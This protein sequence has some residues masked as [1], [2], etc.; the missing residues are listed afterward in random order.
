MLSDAFW[1]SRFDA[2]PH[3][4]GTAVQLNKHP[5]TIVGVA[6]SSF[7]G[8]DLF[9]WPDFWMPIVN[10]GQTDG[11]DFLRN[12]GNHTLWIV[13][14]L[15]PRLTVQQATDNLN[16]IAGELGKQYPG[17]D[18]GMRARLVKPGLMGDVLTDATRAFLFGVFV[19]AFAGPAGGMR[20]PGKHLRRARQPIAAANWRSGWQLV[21]VAGT[22]FANC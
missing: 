12:R 1:R 2:D 14:L 17:N 19:L 18:Q 11:Y 6:P 15:K 7:H 4:V 5:F 16:A 22:F 20:Q 3:V 10:E 8:V 13:G 9:M 21:P